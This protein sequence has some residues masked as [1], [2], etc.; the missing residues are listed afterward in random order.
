MNCA[1]ASKSNQKKRNVRAGDRLQI[2]LSSPGLTG[3]SN[4]IPAFAGMTKV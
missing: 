4:W 2:A 1:E 3:G